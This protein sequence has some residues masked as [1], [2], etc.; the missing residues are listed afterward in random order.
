MAD[1]GHAARPFADGEAGT[2]LAPEDAAKY[3]AADEEEGSIAEAGPEQR[4]RPSPRALL[5]W[6]AAAAGALCFAAAAQQHAE[7]AASRGATAAPE[8]LPPAAQEEKLVPHTVAQYV[9]DPF[10]MCRDYHRTQKPVVDLVLAMALMQLVLTVTSVMPKPLGGG[11]PICPGLVALFG[12]LCG[13]V[14]GVYHIIDALLSAPPQS[15]A[16]SSWGSYEFRFWI[17]AQQ[18]TFPKLVVYFFY[19]GVSVYYTVWHP[20]EGG[21]KLEWGHWRERAM[22]VTLAIAGL[23]IGIVAVPLAVTHILAQVVLLPSVVFVNVIDP[24]WWNMLGLII[25]TIL[26]VSFMLLGPSGAIVYWST[27]WCHAEEGED[28]R[29]AGVRTSKNLLFTK[30]ATVMAILTTMVVQDCTSSS[31]LVYHH[32]AAP[33]KAVLDVFGSRQVCAFHICISNLVEGLE[34]GDHLGHRFQQFATAMI[35]A[36]EF[37]I[38]ATETLFPVDCYD[39]DGNIIYE[40]NYENFLIAASVLFGFVVLGFVLNPAR[41]EILT[42]FYDLWIKKG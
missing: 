30:A 1:G 32:A 42:V 40:H 15:L 3:G 36:D 22:H 16:L 37:L 19:M 26:V 35:T 14:A 31:I 4:S 6:S 28:P 5:C 34:P 17:A 24:A 33:W 2:L 25:G 41:K 9:T 21:T 11:D 39:K 10:A 29:K 38:N 7:S 27:Y 13:S 12:S 20:L 23:G 8:P 18:P